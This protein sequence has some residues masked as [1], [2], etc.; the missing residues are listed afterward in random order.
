M[1]GRA[2]ITLE[3]PAQEYAIIKKEAK[4]MGL[5]VRVFIVGAAV[6]KAMEVLK[7]AAR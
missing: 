5:S 2:S 6:A 1:A 4:R 3:I 7:Q